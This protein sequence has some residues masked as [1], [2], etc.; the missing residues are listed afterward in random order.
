MRVWD[1]EGRMTGEERRTEM[2]SVKDREE[3]R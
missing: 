1:N 3:M 2:N